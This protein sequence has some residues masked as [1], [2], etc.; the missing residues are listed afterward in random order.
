MSSDTTPPHAPG[1]IPAR[2]TPTWEMELLISGATVFGLM[3]MPG[4]ADK[5]LFHVH[6]TGAE[7]VSGFVLPLWIYVKSALVTLIAT[8]V[9]H[10]AL[11]GYWIALVGLSSVYPDGI[12]WAQVAQRTGPFMLAWMKERFGDIDATIER[13]DNR[14]TRVFGVGFAV[15]TLMLIPIGLVLVLLAVMWIVTKTVGDVP[16]LLEAGFMLFALLPV[17]F[18]IAVMIDRRRGATLPPGGRASRWIRG[19]QRAY[20][21]LGLG[22]G[23]NPLLLLFSSHEGNRRTV[24]VLVVTM[25][26]TFAIFFLQA[27]GARL[28]W[29]FGDFSGLPEDTRGAAALVL[30]AHYDSQRGDGVML[31][32]VPTIPD[33]VV[34]GPYLRLFIPY[35]PRRHGESMRSACPGM[36][37]DDADARARLACLQSLHAVAIDG[38]PVDVPFDAAED[39]LTGQRGM[40]AMIPMVDVAPGRHELTVSPAPLDRDRA[41][42]ADPI[43]LYRIPFWR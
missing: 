2:T 20:Q 5:F 31:V 1:T 14:A 41:E 13:A 33:P 3:Q 30:P 38:V 43:T 18:A 26:L 21:R 9:A 34:R 8:F 22:Q 37:R 42:G 29:E 15:A 24:T 16:Y 23:N 11:R 39:P 7:V 17:P 27:V 4:L 35:F 28:G 36:L 32:P 25:G 12:R 40:L 6:N 19:V 10:L